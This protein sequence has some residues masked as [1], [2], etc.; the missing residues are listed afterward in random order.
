MPTPS[1]PTAPKTTVSITG[2]LNIGEA[3][4]VIPIKLDTVLP[5]KTPGVYVFDYKATDLDTAVTIPVGPFFT[6]ATN[7]LG[8]L[9]ISASDLPTSLQNLA[10]NVEKL[11]LDTSGNYDV[12]VQLGTKT[13]GKWSATWKPISALPLTLDLVT[14]EVTNM[15][16]PAPAAFVQEVSGR[17]QTVVRPA[18]QRPSAQA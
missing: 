5:P 8:A 9:G 13:A 4:T 11:H 18:T 15:P 2:T 12:E 1:A 16:A 7:Q 17:T 3:L 10:V 6:W 14:F